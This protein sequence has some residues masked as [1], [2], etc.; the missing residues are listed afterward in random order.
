MTDSIPAVPLSAPGRSPYGDTQAM[1][2]VQALVT[3]P[4]R[5]KGEDAVDEVTEI[6]RRTGRSTATPRLMTV[7]QDTGRN[8][9][10]CVFISAEGTAI[11]VSQDPGT[12]ALR[13]TLMVLNTL[14]EQ[15]LQ[16]EADGRQ[17]V[18]VTEVTEDTDA[19]GR[20]SAADPGEGGAW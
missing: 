6:V 4:G 9:L 20:E 3:S 2:D 14:D 15:H 19:G 17:L 7:H 10:P 13:I 8:G 1:D 16:V 12:G 5:P 11:R 18:P